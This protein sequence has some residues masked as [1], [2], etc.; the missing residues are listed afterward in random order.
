MMV[1]GAAVRV[2]NL[3]VVEEDICLVALEVGN[4]SVE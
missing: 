1:V 4:P 3:F 2:G